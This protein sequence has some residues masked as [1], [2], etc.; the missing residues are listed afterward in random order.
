MSRKTILDTWPTEALWNE[1]QVSRFTGES[2]KTLQNRRVKGNGIPFVKL[3]RL[4]R[5]RPSDVQTHVDANVRQSTS[6]S[7]FQ[8]VR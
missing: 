8:G 2:V 1:D 5:Y 4:V 7:S 6:S 3:G